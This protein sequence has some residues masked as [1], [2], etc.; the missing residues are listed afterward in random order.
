MHKEKTIDNFKK[1]HKFVID[2]LSLSKKEKEKLLFVFLQLS[3]DDIKNILMAI[4][5][6]SDFLKKIVLLIDDEKIDDFIKLI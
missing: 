4:K 2:D 5:K 6:D 3:H 1:L